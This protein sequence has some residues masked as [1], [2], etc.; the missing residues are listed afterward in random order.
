MI[1]GMNRCPETGSFDAAERFDP[2]QTLRI[3]VKFKLGQSGN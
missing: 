3:L 1:D 2:G